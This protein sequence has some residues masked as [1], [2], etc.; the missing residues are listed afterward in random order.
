V[1]ALAAELMKLS[2][3]DRERLAAF[4]LGKADNA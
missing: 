1:E 2:L 4:L 3:V